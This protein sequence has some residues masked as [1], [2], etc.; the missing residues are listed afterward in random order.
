MES[1]LFERAKWVRFSN[2]QNDARSTKPIKLLSEISRYLKHVTAKNDWGI[3][4]VNSLKDRSTE[5][6]CEDTTL[7]SCIGPERW[8]PLRT[9]FRN[10]GR[11][12]R[13][14]GISPVQSR[15]LLTFR[16]KSREL[17][18]WSGKIHS[19]LQTYTDN[20]LYWH[21]CSVV[22]WENVSSL[23]FFWKRKRLHKCI[24]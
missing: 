21:V 20:L 14:V 24:K 23:L 17:Q 2:L 9:K 13:D 16:K 22:T 3:C 10:T 15:E 6:K 11:V 4:P 1:L 8:F 18:N 19:I 7:N 5:Y 12:K